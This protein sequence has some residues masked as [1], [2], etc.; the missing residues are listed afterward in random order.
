MT[1]KQSTLKALSSMLIIVMFFGLSGGVFAAT[2]TGVKASSGKT[3]VISKKTT[4]VKKTTKKKKT[5]KKRKEKLILNPPLIDPLHPP[6][7]R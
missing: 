4:S 7:G 6:G 5:K 2:K 3:K 1:M